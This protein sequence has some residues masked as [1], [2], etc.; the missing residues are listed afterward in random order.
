LR[1]GEI[2]KKVYFMDALSMTPQEVASSFLEFL[3]KEFLRS[4]RDPYDTMM[5]QARQK[6]GPLEPASHVVYVPSLLLGGAE[7]INRVQ[8]MDARSAMICNG[9]IAVQIDAGPH[10]RAV[11]A[12]EP[13]D[14]ELRRTRLR[15]VWG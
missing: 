3:E 10:G 4:A 1:R 14:D 7:D 15:V 6:L 8:K 5:K 13:Y 9:D 12:V 2:E 11:K